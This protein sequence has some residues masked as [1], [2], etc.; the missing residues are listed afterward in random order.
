MFLMISL[1]F[2]L[3]ISEKEG[4]L[5]IGEAGTIT[6][7]RYVNGIPFPHWQGDP[8]SGIGPIHPSRIVH[9]SP[10]IYEFGEPIGGTYPISM[11]P[12]YWYK[13]IET[14]FDLGGL[15]TRLLSSS[16]VY[17]ELFFQKQGTLVAFVLAFYLMGQ[18]RGYSSFDI[19]Q[20]WALVIPAV[21]AL[22]LYA[23]VLV[24]SRYVGVFILLFWADVLANIR[25][26]KKENDKFWLKT[27]VMIACLGLLLNIVLFN[28]DGFARLN[29]SLTGGRVIQEPSPA[30][31]LAVAQALIDLGI[32]P[33]DRVGVIGYAYD[34]FWAR[35]AR[36]KIVAEMLEVDAVRFWRH[37]ETLEQSVLRAFA[38]TGSKAVIAEYVTDDVPLKNWHRVGN[39]STYI[40][41]FGD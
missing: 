13:G 14:N 33:G 16:L 36:V 17:A 34:S 10:T 38:S 28:M 23:T 40:H 19:L 18:K 29:P 2:I 4:K 35:L 25:L 39:S 31:P 27:L 21:F 5:T 26:P 20:R 11:D 3:L 6:Y 22:G 24:Q 12:S 32:K 1:P 8:D 7:L 30:R 41:T 15:L 9:E 37:D